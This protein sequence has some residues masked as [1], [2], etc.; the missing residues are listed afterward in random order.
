[1][2]QIRGGKGPPRTVAQ[3][4]MMMTTT[5]KTMAMMTM[6]QTETSVAII[7]HYRAF[8]MVYVSLTQSPFILDFLHHLNFLITLLFRCQ[9]CFHL[10]AKKHL[11]CWT[12]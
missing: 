7:Q 4:M 3:M 10:H 5:T 9:F 2:S 12:H 6:A 1:L 11:A 8:T